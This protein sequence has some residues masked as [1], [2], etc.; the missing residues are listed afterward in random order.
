MSNFPQVHPQCLLAIGLALAITVGSSL[1]AYAEQILTLQAA[2]SLAQQRSPVLK[3]S[4]QD[5]RA[6]DA[7]RAIAGGA[8]LPKVDVTETF[9]NTNNPAQAFGLLLNQGRFT[10]A[11]FNTTT[12]NRP[13]S[14][15]NYRAA[16]TLTQPVYNGGRERL[17]VQMAEIGQAATAENLSHVQQRVL[18]TVTKAYYD[19]VM[20]KAVRVVSRDT[21]QIAEAN[22][23]QI[24]SRFKGGLTV[25]SDLLQAEVR[26]A[27][28]R[29]EAIRA[30][31][32]VRVAAIGLRHA[33]GLNEEV[34]TANPLAVEE[35]RTL[36]LHLLVSRAL[37]QRPD[38]RVLS[39]ELRKT[40]VGV[41][42]AKSAFLPNVNL[43]TSYELNNT[44]PISP[45]GSNNYVALGIVSLNLF[46]GMSDQAQVQKAKANEEKVRELM[47]AKRREIEVEVVDAYYALSAAS[48]RIMVTQS[49]VTQAEENLRIV[50]NRYQSGLSP[51][52]DM[53]TAE[54]A[55]N[56]VKQNRIH[57][58]Y[59]LQVGRA[60]LDLMIGE[61]HQT[62]QGDR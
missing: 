48:G 22:L 11:D 20:A 2:L 41:Q 42:M 18:F 23:K 9:T 6:S 5:L 43:Q 58:M 37:D 53:L 16:V 10:A 19:L 51:V 15:E 13:G 26:L 4:R 30:D 1:V 55:F 62:G 45:N 32:A 52:L 44:A 61:F 14:T 7:Q 33:I 28:L 50:G 60:R 57:A 8:Y 40:Q 59:D 29:E 38:F 12:L 36:D 3:A 25:K 34:D 35:G 21:V 54:L 31:Q 24:Q 17:G 46:N 47:E 56:Q 49:A 27:G 39:A